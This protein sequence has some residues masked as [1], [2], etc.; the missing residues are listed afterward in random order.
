[1]EDSKQ[2]AKIISVEA[3]YRVRLPQPLCRQVV[4]IAGSKP[5]AAWLLVGSS[6]RCRLLSALELGTDPQLRALKDAISSSAAERATS[7]VEFEEESQVALGQRLLEIQLT[8]HKTSGW[9]FTLPRVLAAIMQLS[10]KESEVA[11]LFVEDHI[12][13]WTIDTLR[14]AVSVPLSEIV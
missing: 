10:P 9:R 14:E 8:L 2:E 12:E 11:A 3:S 6:G 7:V 13:L 5:L 4:W 1:V